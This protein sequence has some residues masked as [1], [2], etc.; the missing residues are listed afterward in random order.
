MINKQYA[1][2]LL[3]IESCKLQ[4]EVD[5][6]IENRLLPIVNCLLPTD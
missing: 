5:R 6:Q 1:K 2:S 4:S 3:N